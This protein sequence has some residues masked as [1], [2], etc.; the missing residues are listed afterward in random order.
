MKLLSKK[1]VRELVLFSYAH[2]ARLEAAGKFPK[3]VPIGR[4]GSGTWS[5]RYWTGSRR[6][7][8]NET[9]AS[10][11]GSVAAAGISSRRFSFGDRKSASIRSFGNCG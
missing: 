6:V 2:T 7:S 10:L 5:R 1:A 8:L 4:T 3:R 11:S 9:S